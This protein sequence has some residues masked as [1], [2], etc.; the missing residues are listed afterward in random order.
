MPFLFLLQ[1][2]AP[3]DAAMI[4]V[5]LAIAIPAALII[6]A[7]IRMWRDARHDRR[8]CG[9]GCIC[10]GENRVSVRQNVAVHVTQPNYPPQQPQ[11]IYL[12]APQQPAQPQVV[13]LPAPQQQMTY[14]APP[15]YLPAPQ[16][17]PQQRH[18]SAPQQHYLP[19]P[20]NQ[21]VQ[22][23]PQ[24]QPQEGYSH[25]SYYAG[26]EPIVEDYQPETAYYLPQ[27]EVRLLP[28]QQSE[29]VRQSAERQKG[30]RGRK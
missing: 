9:P 15:Q 28:P 16:H 18:L 20:T 10:G 25:P 6:P 24:Y 5:I 17:L 4:G 22:Y 2:A 8:T 3:A 26:P 1:D 13:Y 7:A 19:A 14:P 11:V 21:P 12:Q 29:G 23:V 27:R 30:K